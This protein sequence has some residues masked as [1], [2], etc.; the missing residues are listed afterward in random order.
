MIRSMLDAKATAHDLRPFDYYPVAL[1]DTTWE[2]TLADFD[3]DLDQVVLPQKAE[4]ER[5]TTDELDAA[6]ESF[7]A[8]LRER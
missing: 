6:V 3:V 2:L 1:C 5:L 8:A 7:I 4:G